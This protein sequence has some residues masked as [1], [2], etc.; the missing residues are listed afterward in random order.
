MHLPWIATIDALIAA[1]RAERDFETVPDGTLSIILD[2]VQIQ[3]MHAVS[4]LERLRH[5]IYAIATRLP[6]S[7]FDVSRTLGRTDSLDSLERRLI[8]Y[9]QQEGREGLARLVE[10]GGLFGPVFGAHLAAVIRGEHKLKAGTQSTFREGRERRYA[11]K[12][13]ATIEH[14]YGTSRAEAVRLY[15]AVAF[16]DDPEAR[17]DERVR[18]WVERLQAEAKKKLMEPELTDRD[19]R[20]WHTL[21]VGLRPDLPLGYLRGQAYPKGMDSLPPETR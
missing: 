6:V 13:I 7:D 12:Q 2:D 16:P 21:I 20:H 3:L 18:K 17:R 10:H 5:E 19:A 15:A 9:P 1:L 11:V 14:L 4:D 8:R